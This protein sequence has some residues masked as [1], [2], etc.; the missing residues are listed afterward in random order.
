[1]ASRDSRQQVE[2]ELLRLCHSGPEID[3]LQAGVLRSLR[4]LM[5]VD[6]AFFAT[7]DPGTLLFTGAF[8]EEPLR[9][10]APRFLDNE[11]RGEDVNSFV[12]LATSEPTVASL[13]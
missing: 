11:L 9:A 5:P 13:D 6:A 8:S 1:M 7:A 4:R 10:S 12:S 3:E 2:G